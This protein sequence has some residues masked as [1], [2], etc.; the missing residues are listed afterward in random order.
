MSQSQAETEKPIFIDVNDPDQVIT[1]EILLEHNNPFNFS[2][3][4]AGGYEKEGIRIDPESLRGLYRFE[5]FDDAVA[6]QLRVLELSGRETLNLG[7]QTFN[8]QTPQGKADYMKAKAVR[9]L[10]NG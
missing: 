1:P 4:N 3:K 9:S 8:I 2:V 7:E 6:L 5:S 10:N